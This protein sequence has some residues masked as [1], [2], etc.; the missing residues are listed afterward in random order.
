L[1]APVAAIVGIDMTLGQRL[2][3]AIELSRL[4]LEPACRRLLRDF[5]QRDVRQQEPRPANTKLAK[6]VR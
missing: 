2:R 6:N 1:F 4:G 3:R 5:L